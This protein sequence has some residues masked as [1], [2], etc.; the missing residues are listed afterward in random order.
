MEANIKMNNQTNDQSETM[1]IVCVLEQVGSNQ[2]YH[3]DKRLV[4]TM[5]RA[6]QPFLEHLVNGAKET[7]ERLSSEVDDHYV[8]IDSKELAEE[9]GITYVPNLVMPQE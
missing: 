7:A 2:D 3:T 5:Q 9:Y 8:G 6:T 4:N 1:N